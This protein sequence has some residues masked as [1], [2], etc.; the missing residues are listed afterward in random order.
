MAEVRVEM[1]EFVRQA[2]VDACPSGILG[3]LACVSKGFRNACG[4]EA[5]RRS[6]AAG[7]EGARIHRTPVCLLE[8]PGEVVWAIE[9]G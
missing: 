7:T 9:C 4:E 5:E 3:K 8:T 1:P 6:R 2:V